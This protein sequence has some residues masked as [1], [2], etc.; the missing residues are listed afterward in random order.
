MTFKKIVLFVLISLAFNLSFGANANA[1][2]LSL[3][4]RIGSDGTRSVIKMHG[5]GLKGK[6]YAKIFSGDNFKQSEDKV[7]DGSGV[8]DFKL[9]SDPNFIANNPGMI[10]IPSD[11]IQKREVAGVLRRAG[12]FAR[13]GAI[14]T[15]CKPLRAQ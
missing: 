3:T 7:A 4:C 2:S 9:D 12:T 13:I 10:E 5:T 1:G 6:Y 11:F 8:I 15:R 14:R